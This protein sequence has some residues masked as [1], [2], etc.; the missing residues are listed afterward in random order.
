L[1]QSLIDY[2][3]YD[4]DQFTTDGVKAGLFEDLFSVSQMRFDTFSAWLR[5]YDLWRRHKG[6]PLCTTSP[7][8]VTVQRV[9]DHGYV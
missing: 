6:Y 9:S 2:I 4:L 5:R 3:V 7:P 1:I 8:K